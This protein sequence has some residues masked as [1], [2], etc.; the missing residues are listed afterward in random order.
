MVDDLHEMDVR[1]VEAPGILDLGVLLT[2]NA[3]RVIGG[4]LVGAIRAF[5][6]AL[7][8]RRTHKSTPLLKFTEAEM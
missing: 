2:E 6:L 5:F 3:W 4:A 7:V 1:V 8:L